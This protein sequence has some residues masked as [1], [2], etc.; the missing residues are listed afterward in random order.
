[1]KFKTASWETVIDSPLFAGKYMR[2]Y[3][4]DPGGRSRVTLNTMGD[5]AGAGERVGRHHRRRCA[6]W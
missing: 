3:D 2:K 6:T 1:M 4:L 5:E